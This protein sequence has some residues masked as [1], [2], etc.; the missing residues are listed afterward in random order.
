[1]SEGKIALVAGIDHYPSASLS[2]CVNDAEKI[3][4]L[5][6]KNHDGSKNF[7]VNYLLSSRTNVTRQVLKKEIDRLFIG[8]ND[9]DTALFYFAGHGN[10]NAYGGHLATADTRQY[11][12]GVSMDDV[13]KL[14]NHSK[15][16]NKIIILDCCHAG[17]MGSRALPHENLLSELANGVT[18]LSSSREFEASEEKNGEGIFTS[19]LIDALKGQ[20]S[21]LMGKIL[22]SAIYAYMDRALGYW[23]QR[24]VFKTNVSKLV[25]LRQVPPP[26]ELN[27]INNI[28]VYF[29]SP[30]QE[31]QLDP[32]FEDTEADSCKT[33][34]IIFKELQKM[35]GVGL[36][37]PV[38]EDHMYYAAINSKSCQL[39]AMGK[40]YWGLVKS[41]RL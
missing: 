10:L 3:G 17:Y 15:I 5:L 7:E 4:A 35:V 32:S 14:A 25:S 20:C 13:L 8:G 41:G 39:T 40:Q 24:P 30:D 38:G 31:F 19:L 26:I 23:S 37:T 16:K 2:G 1:M 33:N 12:E 18:I 21:D 11:D 28:T 22:P 9:V 36:V 27:V 6:S 34:I 29:Q